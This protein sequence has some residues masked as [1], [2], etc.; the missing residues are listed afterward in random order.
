MRVSLYSVRPN[1]AGPSTRRRVQSEERPQDMAELCARMNEVREEV[2]GFQ[3]ATMERFTVIDQNMDRLDSNMDTQKQFFTQELK[4][5][6]MTAQTAF[7]QSSENRQSINTILTYS[8]QSAQF[9]STLLDRLDNL[10]FDLP[11]TLDRWA[12]RRFAEQSGPS[13]VDASQ[14]HHQR[15]QSSAPHIPIPSMQ[16]P[17]ITLPGIGGQEPVKPTTSTNPPTPP[18]SSQPLSQSVWKEFMQSSSSGEEA[19]SG[20]SRSGGSQRASQVKVETE[21]SEQ[22]QWPTSEATQGQQN[23]STLP[24]VQDTMVTTE[25]GGPHHENPVPTGDDVEINDPSFPSE[26]AITAD[27]IDTF[28]ASTNND[29]IQND[30]SIAP[31]ISTLLVDPIDNDFPDGSQHET[32]RHDEDHIMSDVPGTEGDIVQNL[33]VNANGVNTV[34]GGD[35]VVAKGKEQA[36]TDVEMRIIRMPVQSEG[37]HGVQQ[38]S[39]LS[40]IQDENVV[41]Q[42][43]PNETYGNVNIIPPTPVASQTSLRSSPSVISHMTVHPPPGLLAEGPERPRSD[44]EEAATNQSL[45]PGPVTRSRSGSRSTGSEAVSR[46]PSV[47]PSR[48]PKSKGRKMK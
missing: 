24:I 43:M 13:T 12:N 31:L 30:D 2:R 10:R 38:D 22:V 33:G 7:D 40:V 26:N 32:P 18:S 20:P 6:Q 48:K 14:L 9:M 3:H 11:G 19:E 41:V 29:P 28:S 39:D 25:I 36:T 23:R 45:R 47:P 35:V 46:S 17:I 42:T 44:A 34:G 15:F 1:E 21:D 5:T 16:L 27:P 4:T 8:G 37:P